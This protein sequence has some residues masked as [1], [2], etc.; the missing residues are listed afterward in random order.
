MSTLRRKF[1]EN[2]SGV[3]LD[4]GPLHRP[5][6]KHDGMTVVYVDRMPVEELR[7]QYPELSVQPLVEPDI[8]DDAET[9]DEIDD[10]TFDFVISAHVIEHMRNPIAALRTWL[11]VL[12]PRGLLYLVVPDYRRIFDRLRE[13]TSHEHL[14]DDF[15]NLLHHDPKKDWEH[16]LEYAEKVNRDY[17]G[18]DIEVV[19]EAKRLRDINYSIHY[20][21]FIPEDVVW[22]LDYVNKNVANLRVIH[23]PVAAEDSEE[24]HLLVRKL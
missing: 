20:H 5:M 13:R 8:L 14:L 7:K 6:E 4:I 22:M 11:R 9:L 19:E 15:L 3:G 10:E 12:K 23:G 18:R 24:F 17:F 21:C 16:Y 2:L 1:A